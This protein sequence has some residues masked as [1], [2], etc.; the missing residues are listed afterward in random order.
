VYDAAVRKIG[1]K[2]ITVETPD[3]L[4]NALDPHGGCYT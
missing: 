2:M 3:A 4:A 1:V